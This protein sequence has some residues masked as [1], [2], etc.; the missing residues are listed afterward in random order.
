MNNE[1]IDIAM[2]NQ[3][4]Q[5]EPIKYVKKTR[6]IFSIL[7]V[8]GGGCSS[9]HRIISSFYNQ[10][11]W[12]DIINVGGIKFIATNTD[13][14]SLYSCNLVET[15]IQLGNDGLGAGSDP[16]KGKAAAEFSVSEIQKAIED[17]DIVIIV[18]CFGGGTGTGSSPY[19]ANVA[20]EMGKLVICFI[21]K[22]FKCEGDRKMELA[23]EGIKN[24]KDVADT[25]VVFSNQLLF[26][27]INS[28]TPI[29]EAYNIAD[30]I[31]T[32]FIKSFIRILKF[33][34]LMNVDFADFKKATENMG[35]AVFGFGEAE[36]DGCGIKA[37]EKALSN[38]LLEPINNHRLMGAQNVLIHITGD[39]RLTL[40][41]IDEIVNYICQY[42]DKSNC[43]IKIG[44]T[45]VENSNPDDNNYSENTGFI[46]ITSNSSS[47]EEKKKFIQVLFI[48]TGFPKD[49]P[50]EKEKIINI[51]NDS[52]DNNIEENQEVQEEKKTK[53]GWS[54]FFNTNKNEDL[55]QE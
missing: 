37:A 47:S 22:P 38:P 31:I 36:G 29:I 16:E 33:P 51:E 3:N 45:I 20:K 52:I 53:T 2:H 44:T 40:V 11:S 55:E 1:N 34:D 28:N 50:Q 7:G 30:S 23:E 39:K 35:L 46:D 48:A 43:C 17:S 27:V 19:I 14:Q 54:W 8:G 18:S 26:N 42:T 6:P 9:L 41:E 25:I 15:C 13:H 21:I 10:S 5:K 4:A 12:E 32:E 24:I 49:T